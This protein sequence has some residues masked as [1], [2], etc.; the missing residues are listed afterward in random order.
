MGNPAANNALPMALASACLMWTGGCSTGPTKSTLP[1]L[2]NAPTELLAPSSNANIV[3]GTP[4][5][6]YQRIARQASKCWFGPFGSVHD[7]FM[8]SADV[9]P[10]TSSAPVTMAI[11]RRIAKS[12]KPWGP[13]LLRVQF[14]GTTSTTVSFQNLGLKPPIRSRMTQGVLHWANGKQTCPPLQDPASR[15]PPAPQ[16]KQSTLPGRTKR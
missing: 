13:T 16:P 8:M 2:P 6:I 1:S 14:S 5:E 4:S 10:P 7:R 15:Q 3:T 12:K 11:H 9:P